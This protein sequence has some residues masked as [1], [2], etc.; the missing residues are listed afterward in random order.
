M[1]EV[2]RARSEADHWKT[3]A[4]GGKIDQ[5][6]QHSFD[7][8]LPGP[9]PAHLNRHEISNLPES[10]Y[11]SRDDTPLD[12][13]PTHSS[14]SDQPPFKRR[15]VSMRTD[16]AKVGSN[17]QH[18]GQGIFKPPYSHIQVTSPPVQDVTQPPPLPAK[19]MADDILNY[20][21]HS[22][23]RTLPILDWKSFEEQY[24]T[25]YRKG[26]TYRKDHAWLGLFFSILA[27][28]TLHRS[29]VEA[30]QYLD[31]SRS[32]MDV[33]TDD[34][35]L[36][37]ARVALLTSMFLVEINLKSAGWTS[38]GIA[39]RVA[40]DLGLNCEAG[41]WSAVEEEMRRRLWWCIYACNT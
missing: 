9:D 35:T 12:T 2:A 11:V 3:L 5:A 24:E 27:I 37:H 34:L 26:L 10:D 6:T 39:T 8:Q 13:S 41:T 20:Y 29:R 23:H 21:H 28:G 17:M 32:Y 18:Y 31:T 33:W 14:V 19:C 25:V 1:K 7:A 15:K 4:T 16:L 36:D 40:F 38:L 22:I 30:K